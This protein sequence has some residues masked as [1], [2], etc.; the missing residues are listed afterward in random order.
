[1][2]LFTFQRFG[3]GK[4]GYTFAPIICIWFLF[5][6]GIGVY[7]LKK[8]DPSVIK[9][10]NPKYIIDYFVRNKK[11][12]W[13][14]LGGI[15]LAITGT[16]T[17]VKTT[18]SVTRHMLFFLVTRHVCFVFK[19]NTGTEAL[20][21]DVG[22]FTVRSIQISMCT[23]TYPALVLAYTGQASYLRKNKLDV[24]DTFFK[25]IPGGVYIF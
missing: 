4:V 5:I 20:F 22:H 23:V 19:L 17:H 2:G 14:S 8:Y 24:P 13:I 9:A 3:T 15:V 12:A 16:C 25:S 10:I 21:A 1:M 11:R 6:A 18:C 7:N